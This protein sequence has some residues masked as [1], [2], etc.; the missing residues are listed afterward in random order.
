MGIIGVFC[1]NSCKGSHIWMI[2]SHVVSMGL[3][4]CFQGLVVG[5][6]L[7]S[8]IGRWSV[9]ITCHWRCLLAGVIRAGVFAVLLAPVQDGTVLPYQQLWECI[10]CI[11]GGVEGIPCVTRILM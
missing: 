6:R 4:E 2:S 3:V 1:M 8:G 7:L 9:H 11:S 10:L 5:C